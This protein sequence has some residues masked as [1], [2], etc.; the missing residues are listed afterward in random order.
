MSR[1]LL[2]GEG[3]ADLVVPHSVKNAQHLTHVVKEVGP[4]VSQEALAERRRLQAQP[5][6]GLLLPFHGVRSITVVYLHV[7]ILLRVYLQ[8]TNVSAAERRSV[9]EQ[10][11][12]T[13]QY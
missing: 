10:H 5:T 3:D 7:V 12:T 2:V 1:I 11:M 13:L 6:S 4:E 9:F 8:C